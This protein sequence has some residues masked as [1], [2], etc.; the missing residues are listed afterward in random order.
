MEGGKEEV[1]TLLFKACPRCQGDMHETSDMYGRYN[2]CIQCGHIVD[3]PSEPLGG[4]MKVAV[5]TGTRKAGDKTVVA[6]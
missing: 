4:S 5:K 6:A 2:H 1:M 3:L